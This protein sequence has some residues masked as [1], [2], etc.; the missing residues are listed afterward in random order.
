MFSCF[1]SDLPYSK[2]IPVLSSWVTFFS[3]L[4]SCCPVSSSW[5]WMQPCRAE[6]SRRVLQRTF[7]WH[8]YLYTPVSYLSFQKQ[9]NIVD[10][11]PVWD[12]PILLCL[13]NS[14]LSCIW[15]NCCSH[16]YEHISFVPVELGLIFPCHLSNFRKF[17]DSCSV[18]QSVYRLSAWAWFYL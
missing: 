12:S 16:Q 11:C 14:S 7:R 3:T 4:H 5:G 10:L 17:S 6:Q 15:T 18:I 9:C 13:Y 1:L 8:F 2:E